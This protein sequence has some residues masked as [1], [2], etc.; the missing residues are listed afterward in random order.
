[1]CMLQC[2]IIRHLPLLKNESEFS[3]SEH[4]EVYHD[5]H[6]VT[7]GTDDSSLDMAFHIDHITNFMVSKWKATIQKFI[8]GSCIHIEYR[9]DI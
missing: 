7:D 1:M 3:T 4:I 2:V 6:V 9:R 8:G 5:T